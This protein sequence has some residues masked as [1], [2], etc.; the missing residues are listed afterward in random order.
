MADNEDMKPFAWAIAIAIGVTGCGSHDHAARAPL[1]ERQRDS[2]LAQSPL[3]GA[4]V[5]GRALTVSDRA[6][7]RAD[8]MDAAADSLFH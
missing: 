4:S 1:T 5:V 8:K 7:A 3:P 6:S 2:V